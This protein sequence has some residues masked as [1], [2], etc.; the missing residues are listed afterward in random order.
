[1]KQRVASHAFFPSQETRDATLA[2]CHEMLHEKW[3][4]VDVI[5]S[6]SACQS[7][8]SQRFVRE[9]RVAD[10][11]ESMHAVRDCNFHS[12]TLSLHVAREPL[13]HDVRPQTRDDESGSLT[14]T[15]W[16]QK[17]TGHDV[18]SVAGACQCQSQFVCRLFT[19]FPSCV[20]FTASRRL[21]PTDMLM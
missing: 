11:R 18:A 10:V 5:K 17:L 19:R 8:L 3:D 21:H 14:H 9:R 4:P 15:H 13:C 16:H 7:R 1:M 12:H 20:C 2:V 6:L